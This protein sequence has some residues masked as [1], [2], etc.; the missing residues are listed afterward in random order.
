VVDTEKITTIWL[1]KKVTTDLECD[2]RLDNG[3][4]LEEDAIMI[5]ASLQKQGIIY[6]P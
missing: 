6:S 1:G 5:R 2:M 4:H 3:D